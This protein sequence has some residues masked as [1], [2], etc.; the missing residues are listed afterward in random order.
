MK[1][2]KIPCITAT[3]IYYNI[4]D[5]DIDIVIEE[6]KREIV[7]DKEF[8]ILQNRFEELCKNVVTEDEGSDNDNNTNTNS[9]NNDGAIRLRNK[10]KKP[11]ISL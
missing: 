10:N 3:T 5:K 4:D 8:K 2:L 6:A 1:I 11:C 7:F 9:T